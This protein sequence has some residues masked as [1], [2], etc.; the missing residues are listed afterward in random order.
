MLFFRSELWHTGSQNTSERIRY[1]I[2]NHY[3]HRTISNR[4]SPWPFSFNQE[5]LATANERQLRLL[6]KHP[7]GA[8][9]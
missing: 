7:E 3:S 4:F 1:L 8:Y 6:G 2:Q 9:G 5:F